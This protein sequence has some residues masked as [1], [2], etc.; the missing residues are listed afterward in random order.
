MSTAKGRRAKSR[1]KIK[2]DP[3]LYE[4][5]LLKDREQKKHQREILMV[6]L[7]E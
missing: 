5:Q 3:E 1:A 6:K 4:A 2:T 7:L